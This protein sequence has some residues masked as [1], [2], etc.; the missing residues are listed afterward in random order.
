VTAGPEESIRAAAKRMDSNDVGCVVVIDGHDH[1]LGVL[2]DRDVVILGLGS[3]R[4]LDATPVSAV[5]SRLTAKVREVTPMARAVVRMGSDGV[6][7]LPVVDHHGRLTG[8]LTWDD[9]LKVVA[10]NLSLAT[11]AIEAQFPPHG[12]EPS[13]RGK[14]TWDLPT[15]RR[16]RYDPVV[17]HPTTQV[18]AI[19]D[20]MEEEGVGCVLVVDEK[21][22]P[23][24]VVTDRDLLR[25]VVAAGLDPDVEVGKVMSQDVVTVPEDTSIR[26]MLEQARAHGIRR[27]PLVNDVGALAGV[28]A[29]DDVIAA[30]TT[31]LEHLRHAVRVELSGT[32]RFRD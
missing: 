12:A 19:V 11:E 4:D 20:E 7:R 21:R 10:S 22:I 30:L 23:V 3:S 32:L 14:D 2:T 31:E 9:A 16:Y 13:D 15:A 5:M 18:S 24:G 6:R 1:P 27:V 8:I 29:L 17:A 28:V 26:E 25:R